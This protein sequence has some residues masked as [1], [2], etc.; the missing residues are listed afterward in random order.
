VQKNILQKQKKHQNIIPKE[1]FTGKN[2]T[3][4]GGV[5]LFRRFFERMDLKTVLAVVGISKRRKDDYSNLDMC[6]CLLHGLMLG[7]FRP[8]HMKELAAD[9][10]CHKIAGLGRFP[11]QGTISKYLNKVTVHKAEHISGVNTH[12]LGGMRKG[13]KDLDTCTMDIDS[14]VVSV[15]GKQH[16]ARKGYNPKKHGR[17]SY[18]PLMCFLGET[19][20]YL[21]GMLRPGNCNSSYKAEDLITGILKK[22][23]EEPAKKLR[24]DS[25]FFSWDF[26]KW[27]WR[28]GIEFYVV[29]PQQPWVQRL[30][31]H[32]GN[33]Q[34][35]PGNR[36]VGQFFLPLGKKEVRF[37][38]IRKWVKKGESPRK[39]LS[40]LNV[41]EELYDYQVIATNSDLPGE[42]VWHFYNKRACCENFIK[43]G[44]YGFGLDK[45][46]CRSWAGA[47][48][49]FELIMLAYNLMNWFKETALGNQK[50]KEMIGTIRWKI[51]WIPAKLVK[52]GRSFKLKLA[53]WWT[54]QRQFQ[55]ARIALT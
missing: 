17:K 12:L 47:R 3:R 42:D 45:S 34:E 40:I 20:D 21:G 27:L 48:L 22:L 8:S 49:Y 36:A 4:F 55:R 39:Q 19:R 46:I 41:Q 30:I 26:L 1:E 11:S 31:L 7:I 18:H 25:G 6:F 13:F 38:V 54:Y 32:I 43:E 44:V 16:R 53:D 50:E 29:V 35:I 51:I 24:A 33:W 14:H 23:P 2:L 37:V 28:H 10:V 9:K 52:R 15:F 5:G